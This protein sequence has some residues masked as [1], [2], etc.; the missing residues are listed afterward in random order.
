MV[1]WLFKLLVTN[2]SEQHLGFCCRLD[3]QFFD[4]H[5]AARFILSQHS[6][7]V[8]R[9]SQSLHQ[10][11]VGFF[12][13]RLQSQLLPRQTLRFLIVAARQAMGCQF[14]EGIQ[15]Q[16]MQLFPFLTQPF[17]ERQA[18]TGEASQEITSI[19]RN[20]LY[21]V[22]TMVWYLEIDKF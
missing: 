5:A 15:G 14:E 21:E 2:A 6:A 10:L 11:A 19:Q 8:A 20:R 22:V 13:P 7:A 3:A 17:V 4:H 1:R 16:A 9:Q 18:V 12:A